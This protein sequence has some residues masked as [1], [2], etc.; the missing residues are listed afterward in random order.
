MSLLK[1][2]RSC[3]FTDSRKDY[4]I[5]IDGNIVGKIGFGE[6]RQFQINEGEHLLFSKSHWVR[7]PSVSFGIKGSETKTFIV[8]RSKNVK[9]VIY[10]FMVISLVSL[11]LTFFKIIKFCCLFKP[12]RVFI[13]FVLLYLRTL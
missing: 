12:S 2:K 3:D 4:E 8:E 10:I 11:I 9:L 5:Y 7:S 6:T 1:I 13:S